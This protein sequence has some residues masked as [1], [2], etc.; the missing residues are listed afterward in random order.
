MKKLLLASLLLSSMTAAEPDIPPI[1]DINNCDNTTIT[2]HLEDHQNDIAD[3]SPLMKASAKGDLKTIKKLHQQGANL[4]QVNKHNASALYYAAQN[5]DNAPDV[6]DY[7]RRHM[8]DKDFEALLQKQVSP[9]G[10]TIAL[11]AVFNLN[12]NL[13]NYR[14]GLAETGVNINFH[15]PTVFA[16]TPKTFAERE[17]MT[18]A[19]R[20]PKGEVNTKDRSHWMQE[21]QQAWQNGLSGSEAQYH[22]NGQKLVQA[23]ASHDNKRI[24]EL[25]AQGID[26]NGRYGQLLATPLNSVVRPAMTKDELVSAQATLLY[27]LEQGA[28]PNNPEGKIMMVSHG[29]RESVFGYDKLL[30]SVITYTREHGTPQELTEYLDMQG[31][32]NGYTKLI[33][34]AFRG[35]NSV[36]KTLLDNGANKS[37]QGYNGITAYKA[38]K[39]YNRQ[40]QAKIIPELMAR[41]KL[42]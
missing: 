22:A 12:E 1:S 40:S 34:A 41:L 31:P 4:G 18:F 16:W 35:H 19:K 9:N 8:S 37:I 24:A 39:I 28:D 7:F 13:V 6:F 23:A 10:H 14:L 27:L 11:E 32:V 30:S 20:L 21:Q 36:I 3:L 2:L 15:S 33:D 5:L 42:S 17:S 26:I 38:A 29:F 25:L